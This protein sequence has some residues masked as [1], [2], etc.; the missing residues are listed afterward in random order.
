MSACL[1]LKLPYRAFISSDSLRPLFR[2]A[3]IYI[4]YNTSTADELTSIKERLF[5]SSSSATNTVSKQLFPNRKSTSPATVSSSVPSSKSKQK[6]KQQKSDNSSQNSEN[7]S[8]SLG[9]T[10]PEEQEEEEEE[11]HESELHSD[12]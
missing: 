2:S 4:L 8:Q 10:Q 11:Q 9:T 6:K 12:E 5:T 7:E 1:S 3:C